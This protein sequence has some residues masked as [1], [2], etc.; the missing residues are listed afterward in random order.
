M[1]PISWGSGDSRVPSAPRF[2]HGELGMQ[3]DFAASG[4]KFNDVA[5]SGEAGSRNIDLSKFVI[6]GSALTGCPRND[7]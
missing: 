5:R 6:P 2:Y 7:S 1:V 4:S 3:Q